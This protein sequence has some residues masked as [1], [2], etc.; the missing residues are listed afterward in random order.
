MTD[1][2]WLNDEAKLFLERGYLLEGE[3]PKQRILDIA[4]H[5]E[6]ILGVEDFAIKFER[7]M[8]Q[9]F[10]SLSSPIWANFG[11]ERGLPHS[12]HPGSPCICCWI[13]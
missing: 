5:A 12:R 13:F 9:G 2:Y 7:Y 3:S 6:K 8:A 1:Y 11:R 10:Y 4:K